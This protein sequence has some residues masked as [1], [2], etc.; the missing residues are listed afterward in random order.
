VHPKGV[1]CTELPWVQLPHDVHRQRA[2][3]DFSRRNSVA[4]RHYLARRNA[5]RSVSFANAAALHSR[6][7]SVPK[8][9][10]SLGLGRASPREAF[11]DLSGA[12]EKEIRRHLKT[13]V[14]AVGAAITVDLRQGDEEDHVLDI[15]RAALAAIRPHLVGLIAE[16]ADRALAAAG[17]ESAN[18]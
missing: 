2:H 14:L 10:R 13:S 11:Y 8:A 9:K 1:V 15:Y 5:L 18:V 17:E 7:C 12:I 6:P 16:D 4:E 3:H